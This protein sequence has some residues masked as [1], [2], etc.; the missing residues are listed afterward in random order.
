MINSGLWQLV[1]RHDKTVNQLSLHDYHKM[2][3]DFGDA[4]IVLKKVFKHRDFRSL[5]QRDAVK[6]VL[7]GNQ[8]TIS[9]FKT[10]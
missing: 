10:K 5:T 4:T 3:L 9:L 1:F 7:R 2:A 8:V 6:A